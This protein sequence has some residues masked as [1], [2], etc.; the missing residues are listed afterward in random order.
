MTSMP[1][2]A[3]HPPIAVASFRKTLPPPVLWGAHELP[4]HGR[5]GAAGL[6]QLEGSSRPTPGR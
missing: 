4:S 6:E 3:A 5:R 2:A 1:S